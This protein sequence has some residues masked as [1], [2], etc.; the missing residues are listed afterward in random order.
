MNY[1]V[2]I[3]AQAEEDLR[4]IFS[5]IAFELQSLQNAE[6]QLDRLEENILSLE[7]MPNRHKAYEKE[8][9]HSR[10]LRVM[11]VDNYLV[12][13]IPNHE[14][15]VVNIVRVM[16]GGRDTDAQLARFTKI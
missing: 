15:K 1:D 13:Y 5:Y 2:Q 14:A 3:S 4:S 7:Q 11:P 9:W 8:P 6:R 12:F 10:G 16:Y